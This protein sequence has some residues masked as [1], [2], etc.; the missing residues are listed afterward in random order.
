MNHAML[1]HSLQGDQE[2]A[3]DLD[4]VLDLEGSSADELA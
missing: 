4:D 2:L 1:V 3:G